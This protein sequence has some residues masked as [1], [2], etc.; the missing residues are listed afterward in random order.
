LRRVGLTRV[1]SCVG[2]LS[3][4]CGTLSQVFKIH[5]ILG[6]SCATMS[7][8]APD[9][10]D[11]VRR[12]AH[13]M[14]PRAATG[15]GTGLFAAL[16]PRLGRRRARASVDLPMGGPRVV[17]LLVLLP[18]HVGGAQ[19]RR[20]QQAAPGRAGRLVRA[21][22]MGQRAAVCEG[23]RRTVGGGGSQGRG[24]G[25]AVVR[26]GACVP[27]RGWCRGWRAHYW[28]L[29]ASGRRGGRKRYTA[30]Y[31]YL[32]VNTSTRELSRGA[33]ASIQTISPRAPYE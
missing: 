9:D 3:R 8:F 27:S 28:R 33:C 18:F 17:V 10:V 12:A 5:R 31:M 24:G 1:A 15:G 4:S 21:V 2:D 11:L 7:A 26:P 20:A 23:R 19:A 14:V 29:A 13:Q 22:S 6:H 25:V 16:S 30:A 32:V